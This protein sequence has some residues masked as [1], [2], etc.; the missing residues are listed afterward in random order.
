MRY[1]LATLIALCSV[2]PVAAQDGQVK[3]GFDG[4]SAF[5][6]NMRRLLEGVAGDLEPILEDLSLRLEGLN[7]YQ[8]PEFLPNGDII[9]RKVAPKDLRP[10]DIPLPFGPED[11]GSVEL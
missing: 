4:M 1:V 8:A 6:E 9:I 11:G 10:K 3:P 2:S 7:G 5:A